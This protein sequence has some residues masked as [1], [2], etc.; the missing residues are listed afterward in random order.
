LKH[1]PY[2]AIIYFAILH[3]MGGRGY[4]HASHTTRQ[5]QARQ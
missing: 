1:F 5:V 3:E 2:M 4:M